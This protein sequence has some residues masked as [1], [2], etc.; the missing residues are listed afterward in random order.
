MKKT[1][2]LAFGAAYPKKEG[3]TV[4]R[5]TGAPVTHLTAKALSQRWHIAVG[6]LSNWRSQLIGPKFTRLPGKNPRRAVVYSVK[7]IERYEK[8]N[9]TPVGRKA[10]R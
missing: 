1:S 5:F 8:K 9:G 3:S 2:S 6:T 7:E 4:D 10:R